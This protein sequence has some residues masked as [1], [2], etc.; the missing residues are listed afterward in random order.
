MTGRDERDFENIVEKLKEASGVD[1]VTVTVVE[2][3]TAKQ[4]GLTIVQAIPLAVL[5]TLIEAVIMGFS[6]MA[7]H[8]VIVEE[9]WVDGPG[10]GFI[11]AAALSLVAIIFMF[12]LRKATT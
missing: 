9:G 11:N 6:L 3:T 4:T 8:H 1:D 12:T 5:G 10:I 7:A 2:P